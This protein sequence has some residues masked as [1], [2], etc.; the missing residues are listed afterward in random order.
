[1]TELVEKAEAVAA[2]AYAPYP[3]YHVGAVVRTDDGRELEGVN[4]ENAAYPLGV[5]AEKSAA[6][7]R[8]SRRL[9]SGP[10]RRTGINA[11]PC[12]AAAS[13]SPSSASRSRL[14]ARRRHDRDVRRGRAPPGDLGLARVVKA[15]FVAVAGRPN[16]GKS[17]LVNA[18]VGE[19]VAITSR[20][21]NTTRRR[22]FGV[23]NGE[24]GSSCSSTCPASRSRWT[25]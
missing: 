22:V 19:K 23:A 4:V 20:V 17:T 6:R 16:V 12:G 14:P 7:R 25:S 18:L 1:M 9:R 13:G 15:G 11:S 8:G 24:A 5:C 21:P 10:D 3:N 2:R